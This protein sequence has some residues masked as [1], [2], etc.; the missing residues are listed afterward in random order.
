MQARPSSRSLASKK[1][2]PQKPGDH[3]REVH[4]RPDPVDVHVAYPGVDVVAARPHLVE[5]ERLQAGRSRAGARP[6]R[7]SRPAC[8]AAPSN[9]QTWC[10]SGVST[11]RGASVLERRREPPL[12]GV[13]GLDH[14]VVDGDHGVAHRPW[15]GLGEEE[16]VRRHVRSM[17]D[18]VPRARGGPPPAA[19]PRGYW[20]EP[21]KGGG[22][23]ALVVVSTFVVLVL[24]VLVA[25]LLR[26]HADI[27]RSLHELGV[28]VGDPASAARRP[29]RPGGTGGGGTG[30]DGGRPGPGGGRDGGGR[31]PGRRRAGR[32]RGE[33]RPAHPARVPLFRLR[34]AA[35]R[36]GTRCRRPGPW[37][38]RTA[39]GS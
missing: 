14:V 24:G 11:I 33:Q 34:D 37:T 28:G 31:D 32:R 27:L 18:V 13:G 16:I 21:G 39:P 25:G 36:S 9:S 19:H 7:S 23:V 1:T 12:E 5:A 10:P 17:P 6:P 3:G 29:A 4:R 20:V 35:P 22:V 8:S 2:R 15:L 38:C 30:T 26:S